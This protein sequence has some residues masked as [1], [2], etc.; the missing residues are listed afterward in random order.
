MTNT[1]VFDRLLEPLSSKAPWL[2]EQRVL[3]IA[4]LAVLA[5]FLVRLVRLVSDWLIKRSAA[6]KMPVRL[7]THQPKFVTLTGLIA[8][9]I[10]FVIYFF[11]VG[12]IVH[13]LT[14][15]NLAA[16]FATASVVGLAIGFGSQGL[17]Q[18]VV[19]GVTLIISDTFDVGDM[20]EVSGQ[21]GRVEKVGLRFT[22]LVNFHNQEVFIPNRIIANLNRFP[23]GGIFAYAD[24]QVST[25]ADRSQV[26][27]KVD[28]I[29][30]GIWGEFGAIVLSEP[31]VSQ[32]EAAHAGGW[33]YLRVRFKIWPGQGALIETAF[34]QRVVEA[35]KQLDP[36]YA[37][38]MVTI[39][40]R[41][42]R[43]EPDAPA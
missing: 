30:K 42:T 23:A 31:E 25:E 43:H 12:F 15:V 35:M 16:Y 32:V 37:D 40:F 6:K 13:E 20:I 14:G 1:N 11:A 27:E 34:K 36:N 7:V 8:S 39:T 21:I 17:V 19:T 28:C 29:A 2:A 22:R 4:V 3:L 33:N 26:T 18:D 38:W 5:H 41:A 24:V 10:T 9:G